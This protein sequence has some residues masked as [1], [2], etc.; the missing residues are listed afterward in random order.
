MSSGSGIIDA[1]AELDD[2]KGARRR[3]KLG[4]G[5][6]GLPAGLRLLGLI[7]VLAIG[8]FLI[9]YISWASWADTPAEA[10]PAASVT[11][12]P[13][14]KTAPLPPPAPAPAP[15]PPTVIPAAAPLPPDPNPEPVYEPEAVKTYAP[16][17]P[18]AEEDPPDDGPTTEELIRQRRL[19]PG[20]GPAPA[21]A[22]APVQVASVEGAGLLG[23]GG[24]ELEASLQPVKLAGAR[25]GIIRNPDMMLALGTAIPCILET[26]LISTVP[27][28]FSCLLPADVYSISGRVV[29]LPRGTKVTGSYGDAEFQQGDRRLFVTGA[30]ARTPEHV[31]ID[32]DSPV[33]GALGEG[34]IGGKIENHWG[35][36]L[37]GA[38]VLSLID[39][40]ARALSGGNSVRGDDNQVTFDNTSDA[41]QEAAA[42]VIEATIDIKPTLTALPGQKISII[43]VRMLDFSEVYELVRR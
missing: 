13:A 18:V 32:L 12:V 36:R 2:I 38:I 39:D 33:S 16:A 5:G 43:T 10:N 27:G 11:A 6:P 14:F 29:L 3:I 7:V 24:S 34:G 1:G 15:V 41:A 25:A 21:G 30:Q 4:G 17:A 37:G 8:L 42:K 19:A 31:V 26:R 35:A 9:I 40:F 22:A 20:W 28:M 23:G